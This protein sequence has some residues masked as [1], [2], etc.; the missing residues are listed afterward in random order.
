MVA[1]QNMIQL[2]LSR[3][4]EPLVAARWREYKWN[5]MR[6]HRLLPFLRKC[7]QACLILVVPPFRGN[8]RDSERIETAVLPKNRDPKQTT[9]ATATRTWKNKRSNWRNNSSARAF[10]NL[11]HFLASLCKTATRN[12][13]NLRRLRTETETATANYFNFHLELDASFIRYA[14]VWRCMR[15]WI[16]VA[17]F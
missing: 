5:T 9:T 15:R 4:S 13:V 10:W 17:I 8:W 1:T 16:N 14:E 12:H 3:S 11:V 2:Q 6:I 7:L